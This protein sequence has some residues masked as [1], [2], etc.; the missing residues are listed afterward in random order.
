[1]ND[2]SHLGSFTARFR[3]TGD[4]PAQLVRGI[5]LLGRNKD[6]EEVLLYGASFAEPK[7]MQA[8][9]EITVQLPAPVWPFAGIAALALKDPQILD[10]AG[11][12]L[13]VAQAAFT[14]EGWKGTPLEASLDP[15]NENIA[16][17]C[18]ARRRPS[19]YK[20]NPEKEERNSIIV[21]MKFQQHMSEA[22]IEQHFRAK[23][24]PIPLGTIETIIKRHKKKIRQGSN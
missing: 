15:F 2:I 18:K 6:G 8:G 16:A 20:K 9:S 10:E 1:M 5:C 24:T 7:L 17:R 21:R 11:R 22:Q 14:R 4:G 12:N 19:T 13:G 3:C 23:G